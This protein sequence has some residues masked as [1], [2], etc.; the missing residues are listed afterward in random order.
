MVWGLDCKAPGFAAVNRLAICGYEIGKG[1]TESAAAP[2]VW[3]AR[4]NSWLFHHE[5][6]H[7]D[8]TKPITSHFIL[9]GK[10]EVKAYISAVSAPSNLLEKLLQPRQRFHPVLCHDSS[11]LSTF[12]PH[13]PFEECIY[14]QPGSRSHLGKCC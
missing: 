10:L 9:T 8:C 1:T 3:P 4:R 14:A 5:S 2:S 11:S 7:S 12:L 13:S 6:S